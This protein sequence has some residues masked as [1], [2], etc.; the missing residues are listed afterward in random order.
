MAK[1]KARRNRRK[2]NDNNKKP[3]I[4]D[5]KS[6]KSDNIKERTSSFNITFTS[7]PI[8]VIALP[9][10]EFFIYCS[11]FTIDVKGNPFSVYW[12]KN[13]N[14]YSVEI[15][16]SK[17]HHV[18]QDGTLKFDDFEK[19]DEGEYFCVVSFSKGDIM[20]PPAKVKIADLSL[21]NNYKEISISLKR[22]ILLEC[23]IHAVPDPQ[24]IWLKDGKR[25]I[26]LNESRTQGLFSLGLSVS[27]SAFAQPWPVFTGPS[28]LI[29]FRTTK[30]LFSLGLSVSR[31]AFAQ[32][33][34][35]F[36]G[37]SS[38][39]GFRTTNTKQ[40]EIFQ[41]SWKSLHILQVVDD[42]AGLYT[43]E[44]SNVLGQLSTTTIVRVGD[45]ASKKQVIRNDLTDAPTLLSGRSVVDAL[46][47]TDVNLQCL[48]SFSHSLWF[49]EGQP[50]NSGSASSL[51]IKNVSLDSAGT[52]TCINAYNQSI[53]W[54][55][56]LQVYGLFLL[57]LFD[58]KSFSK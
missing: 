25:L 24:T 15:V 35:V 36:T 39:I 34:P 54:A 48:W 33:W 38:L 2:V 31:S 21:K 42:D 55:V 4:N 43:C 20:S 50:I 29:G 19:A 11:V 5:N 26:D 23:E 18:L 49:K 16:H 7:S 8:D 3:Y 13:G 53:S 37:P 6:F 40:Q 1:M 41:P 9:N 47:N 52:Y 45:G 44:A 28:S 46:I 51:V 57:I 14:N 30:G 58:E 22:N 56:S 32:P 17:R 10:K 12:M 27:R